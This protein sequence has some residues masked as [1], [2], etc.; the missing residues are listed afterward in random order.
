MEEKS[1]ELVRMKQ[2]LSCTMENVPLQELKR[3]VRQWASP[4][5]GQQDAINRAMIR[6]IDRLQTRLD[7]LLRI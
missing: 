6:S 7:A 1:H 4:G 3:L 2:I 5:I